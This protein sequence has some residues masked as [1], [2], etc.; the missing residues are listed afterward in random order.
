[1]GS[2]LTP[3]QRLARIRQIIEDV[4]NRCMAADGPVTP[5]LQEMRQK[6]ITEI[7]RLAAGA[8]LEQVLGN[9]RARKEPR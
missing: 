4:D 5:T 2:K 7:Y 9:R 6:E 1:M 3:R 8:Y